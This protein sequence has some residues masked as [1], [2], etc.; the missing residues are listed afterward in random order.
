M[1]TF[2]FFSLLA[3]LVETLLVADDLL[4]A[5]SDLVLQTLDLLMGLG[6]F[7]YFCEVVIAVAELRC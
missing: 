5:S 6:E 4:Y 2:H 3:H 1:G 7:I